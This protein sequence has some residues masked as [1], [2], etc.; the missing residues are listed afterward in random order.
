L[1]APDLNSSFAAG[2]VINLYSGDVDLISHPEA[3]KKSVAMKR[4]LRRNYFN[5]VFHG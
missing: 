1:P 4:K 5:G 3:G 2:I